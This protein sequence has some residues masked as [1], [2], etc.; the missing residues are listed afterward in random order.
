MSSKKQ[1]YRGL[2]VSEAF[3]TRKLFAILLLA[4]GALAV[5]WRTSV[6][7]RTDDG[8]GARRFY[9]LV[10]DQ[11]GNPVPNTM[12]EAT[13]SWWG[14]NPTGVGLAE[15]TGDL[16]H[17]TT[18]SVADGTF[19]IE[20]PVR[21]EQ[22]TIDAVKRAGYDW[23]IDWAWTL[24]GPFAREDNRMFRFA[25]RNFRCDT[26]SPDR[27]RPAVFPLHAKGSSQPATRPSRGGSDYR[28]DGKT[29]VNAPAALAV[30]S[31]GPGAPQG[32]AAINAAIRE[33]IEKRNAPATRNAR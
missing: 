22:L 6:D 15:A 10:I 20:V 28:C 19:Q 1:A 18:S 8:G 13:L 30:P 33:Y 24:T 2:H 17:V 11:D 21:F 14:D 5:Y 27:E 25:G 29:I 4:V 9:G 12:I 7:R 3:T 32:N 16:V 31:A 23:V 26:Y